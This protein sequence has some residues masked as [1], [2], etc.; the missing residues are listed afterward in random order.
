MDIKITKKGKILLFIILGIL[1]LGSGGYLLWRVTQKEGV[2]PE[3]GEAADPCKRYSTIIKPDFN[4]PGGTV[5]PFTEK[6]EV[7]LF[8]KNLMGEGNR[9]I[10][11]LQ[12]LPS[13]TPVQITL[14]NTTA[15][16]G[17][18]KTGIK[19]EKG[20]SIKLVTLNDNNN[21]GEA[22]DAECI[23]ETNS[24]YYALGWMIP[25]GGKCGTTLQGPPTGGGSTPYVPV[26]VS[27]DIA[28][29]NSQ[30]NPV[31]S[32]QCWADWMEWP[33][34][35]D[36]NDY[37][38][39]ISYVPEVAPPPPTPVPS[40][41]DGTL[42][43]GE[44]CEL[45]NPT[46]T[47]CTWD[48]CNKQTCACISEPPEP[49]CGDG[50][51][52]PGEQCELGNPTGTQCTWDK[53]NQQTCLCIP[54]PDPRN[55]DWSIVKSATTGYVV[56]NGKNYGKADYTVTVTNVGDG[57]G[58]I[59]KVVDKLD[60]KVLQEY[61]KEISN[62]GVY[63]LNTIIWDLQGE[64]EVF[65]PQ[66]NLKLTYSIQIPQEAFGIYQNTVTAYPRGGEDISDDARVEFT[67]DEEIPEKPPIVPQTG[68]L[69]TVLGRVSLGVSFIFLG[70]LVTQ[71]SKIDYIFNSMSGRTGFNA[72]IREQRKASK[73]RKKLESSFKDD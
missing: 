35:Y 30:G 40:C 71:Y 11:T 7:V 17:S 63:S 15:S 1:V 21:Q 41:G 48:K 6:G 47:Q 33:G 62:S 44:Q 57:E 45:G 28:F 10:L 26:D 38:L 56:I 5:G 59:D 43:A 60:S 29:A 32:K 31:L 53:C 3:D 24:K 18:I 51:L 23:K 37:F 34:D 13:G 27:A 55:P 49:S 14:S 69:D 66:E 52:N 72:E 22:A 36:F 65:S 68:V 16:T 20:E 2:A 70:G 39:Q 67:Y 4:Y 73:R 25:N 46:G 50:S 12:K 19:V 8:F 9:P 61:V 54:E 64:D 58:S 42:D